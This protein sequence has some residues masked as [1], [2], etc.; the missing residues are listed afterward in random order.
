MRETNN[1][2]TIV[3]FSD[4]L[5]YPSETFIRTQAQAL[6][7]FQA[8]FAGSRR[9]PGLNLPDERTYTI[10][11]G[12]LSGR[13]NEVI[14]KLFGRAR[15]LAQKLAELNPV[16][17]HA[18]HGPN[19]LRALPLA[20][21]LKLP[22]IV[23][24]HGSDVTATNLRFRETYFGHRQYMAHKEELQRNG[25]LFIAVSQFI[26]RK[27]LSQGFPDD[28]TTVHYTGV[29]TK[30]FQPA[31]TESEPVI[32]FVGRLTERKG[33]QFLIR[34]AGE[35]QKQLPAVELVIVGDGPLRTDLE[36]EAREKLRRFRFVGV[37]GPD[38]VRQWFNR[39]SVFCAPSVKTYSGEEEAFGMVYAEAQAMSK[40]VVAFDSGGISEVVSHG[41]T[42]FLA[43]ERDWQALATYLLMLLK[44]IDLRKQFGRAGRE[45]IIAEFDLEKRTAILEAIYSKVS[46]IEVLPPKCADSGSHR[47]L[48][49]Y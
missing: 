15:N 14:F 19:G 20:K 2:P 32:L 26:R 25:A 39:A 16:L 12:N 10:S 47:V 41:H 40:P 3:V 42:G 29:D 44:D 48:S 31:N 28:R 9:V 4:H 6:R 45:R 5:L 46:G 24:F 43:P 34:A 11:R 18:H 13:V 21:E 36:K 49:C 35:V 8:V 7:T 33:T 38:E 22:L 1:Q 17:V 37:L 27:L 30:V 23:T